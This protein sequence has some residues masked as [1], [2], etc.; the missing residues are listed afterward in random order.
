MASGS[1]VLADY[2]VSD[3]IKT[4]QHRNVTA[5]DMEVYGVY[6]AAQACD[7]ALPFISLKSVC[8]RGDK[9]KDDKYQQYAAAVSAAAALRFVQN[10]A[11]GLLAE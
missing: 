7:P 1:A 5:L 6:A 3:R 11:A 8:D 10:H 4:T 9:Q 2:R